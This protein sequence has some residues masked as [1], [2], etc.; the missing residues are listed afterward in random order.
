MDRAGKEL[1]DVGEPAEHFNTA[2]SPSGDRLALEI[3][4]PQSGQG[5]LWVR[6]LARNVS[7]RFT[8][9]AADDAAP[10]WSPDGK[11]IYFSSDRSAGKGIYRKPASGAGQ[12]ELVYASE[13]YAAASSISSDGRHMAFH[14]QSGGETGWDLWILPLEGEG[15]GEAYPFLETSFVEVR[16]VFSPDGRWI[17]YDSNESGRREVYALQFPGPGG[18][19][20]ISTEGG[21][22]PSWSADGSEIFY[23]SAD[24]KL[25]RVDVETGETLTVG[26]P[27]ALFEARVH[28]SIQRNRFLAARDGERFL[29]LR[30]LGRDSI[31][32]TTV[33]LNWAAT[34]RE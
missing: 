17:I 11:Y 12:A 30:S 25:V 31:F 15:G 14:R 28:P 19:W 4:D 34:L 20:Q 16:P 2:I 21:S 27:E 26:L 9:D 6:D 5:D 10:L 24:L 23:L 3:D 13:V 8:F 22:E 1:E 18:K 33:V 7:S 29:L 32:P